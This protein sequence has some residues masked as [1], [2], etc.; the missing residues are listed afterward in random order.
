MIVYSDTTPFIALAQADLLDLLPAL[1][2]RIHATPAVIDE[3]AA[4]GPVQVAPLRSLP[5]IVPVDIPSKPL[6]IALSELGAGE[7]ETIGLAVAHPA[8][9]VLMDERLGRRV[10]E[11]LG[12]RVMGTLGVLAKARSERLIESFRGPADAMRRQGIYFHAGL[13]DRIAKTLGE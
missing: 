7:S 12:L 4:G 6:P 1:F 13:I 2:D 10:A 5:W 11:Y 9:L 8:D 3:C